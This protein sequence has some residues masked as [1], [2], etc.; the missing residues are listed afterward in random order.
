MH[1]LFI[2]IL[3][4]TVFSAGS[5]LHA[6][7]SDAPTP[8]AR[9]NAGAVI[10]RPP[11]LY[12]VHGVLKL[13]L[14]YVTRIDSVG[15]T[16]FCFKTQDGL[17]SPT[18]HV[19][20]GDTLDIEVTNSVPS[21]PASAPVE[22]VSNASNACGDKTMTETSLNMHFHGTNTSPTCHSDEVIHTL[23]NSGQTFHYSVRI[24]ADEPPGLYWYHPHV[25]GIAEAAV[26]GG[27]SGAIV[28]EGVENVQPAV[29]GLPE[30]ILV[31]R[32]QNVGASPIPSQAAPAWDVSLNYVPIPR[33]YPRDHRHQSAQAGILARRQRG[34][35]H[36]Y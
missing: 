30:R 36:D 9:P 10:P 18:L 26:L 15:R 4:G 17:E 1:R 5:L 31:I 29:A 13:A 3:L 33:L 6:F 16:L 22:I 23:I 12:S 7:A 24:P 21:L 2:G 11:D 27:A 35:R 34:G 32:D 28:V 19:R 20:P 8:C 25:H 14:S